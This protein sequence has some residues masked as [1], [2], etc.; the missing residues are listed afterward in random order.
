MAI[1]GSSVATG[2]D[3]LRGKLLKR[4]ETWRWGSAAIRLSGEAMQG[5]LDE[6]PVSRPGDRWALLNEG[7]T[8]WDEHRVAVSIKRN[9][10]LGEADWVAKVVKRLGLE[11]TIRRPAGR[12][13]KGAREIPNGRRPR[14]IFCDPVS[15][16]TPYHFPIG[17]RC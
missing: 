4:A 8:E 2:N 1:S 6:W 16:S 3:A 7:Q 5:L 17:W 12:R 11:H 9:R 15:F 10:P 13:R 14:I